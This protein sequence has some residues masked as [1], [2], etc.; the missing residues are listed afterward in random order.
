MLCLVGNSS[1]EILFGNERM[2]YMKAVALTYLP[3]EM[4]Q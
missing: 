3:I 4:E 2:I 1:L